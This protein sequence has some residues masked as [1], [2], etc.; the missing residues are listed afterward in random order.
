[1]ESLEICVGHLT[2]KCP[3][4]KADD[5]NKDCSRYSPTTIRV[6]EIQ[7]HEPKED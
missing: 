2:G 3:K 4:C 6:I 5:K 1:M 7:E